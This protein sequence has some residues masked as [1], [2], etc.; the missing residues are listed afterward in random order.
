MTLVEAR[1]MRL[2]QG[3]TFQTR[4]GADPLEISDLKL[5]PLREPKSGRRYT[6]LRL[7]TRSGLK[8]YGECAPVSP[9]DH[10]LARKL[11]IGSPATAYEI[12]WRK[13]AA[14]PTIRAAINMAQLDILGKHAKAPVYQVLGGPTRF[15]VRGL[16]PL[17]GPASLD[18][19]QAAGFKAFAVP[20]PSNEFRNAGKSYVQKVTTLMDRLR[21]AASSDADFV[22][23]GGGTM[24]PGDAQ[25][26]AAALE[27]FHLLWFDEP[28][29]VA[30]VGVIKKVASESVTP[31]GFGR[32]LREPG[33]FQDLLR[34]DAVD[35][36][37]PDL[38]LHGISQIRRIAAT[39]E[40]YYIAVA[41]YH[42]GGPLA[43][44]AALQLAASLP[45]FFIQQIPLPAD[46]ADRE[47]RAAL[48]SSTPETIKDGFAPL[49][50]AP[51]LGVIVNEPALD[52]YKEVA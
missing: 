13:L 24:V 15:K 12:L 50:T 45:N 32:T 43:T 10:Q 11:A 9:A 49:P 36:L 41:P 3:I 40:T 19:A 20:A 44:A 16:A 52:R 29:R 17:T 31:L 38:S 34:E 25:S 37:R 2:Q 23:D 51:G 1:R 42:D 35:I 30:N 48:L 7:D 26:I 27:R 22:L 21:R 33:E 6:I 14:A 39:A 46:P 18:Q 8:G 28:S 5:W 47:M 4:S